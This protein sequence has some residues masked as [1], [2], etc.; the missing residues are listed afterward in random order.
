MDSDTSVLSQDSRWLLGSYDHNVTPLGLVPG[1]N[2]IV[3]IPPLAQATYGPV[4]TSY[5]VFTSLT[6]KT[7]CSAN[8]LE[9]KFHWP[10]HNI[11]L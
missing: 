4:R 6:L 11:R 1:S 3:E 9:L 8:I 7:H 2:I 5:H 10:E